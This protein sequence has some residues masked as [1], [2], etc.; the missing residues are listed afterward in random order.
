M[1]DHLVIHEVEEFPTAYFKLIT[2]G[3]NRVET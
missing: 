3:R 2:K 1:L